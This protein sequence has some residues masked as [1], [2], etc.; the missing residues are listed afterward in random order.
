MEPQHLTFDA[1]VNYMSTVQG[2]VA[3]EF[4]LTVL[5]IGI[6]STVV[7]IISC[8]ALHKTKEDG[9]ILG[10]VFGFLIGFFCVAIGIGEYYSGKAH[11]AAPEY[12]AAKAMSPWNTPSGE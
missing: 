11:A 5:F 10:I 7:G 12:Y 8:K 9:W 2:T 3:M 4:G 6:F 1:L